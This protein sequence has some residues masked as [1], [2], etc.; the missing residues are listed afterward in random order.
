MDFHPAQRAEESRAF[1]RA[2]SVIQTECDES[3]F[4]FDGK[5]NLKNF[6]ESNDMNH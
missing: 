2:F 1:R 6:H 3:P 5:E 4:E